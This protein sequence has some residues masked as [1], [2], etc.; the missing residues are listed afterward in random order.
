MTI[1]PSDGTPLGAIMDE[2]GDLRV[3]CG[4]PGLRDMVRASE[5]VLKQPVARQVQL[6]PLSLT[7]L[8]DRLAGRRASWPSLPWVLSFVAA[9]HEHRARQGLGPPPDHAVLTEWADRY[10]AHLAADASRGRGAPGRVGGGAAEDAAADEEPAPGGDRAAHRGPPLVGSAPAAAYAV[11]T[12]GPQALP[13]GAAGAPP[14]AS[15]SGG[16]ADGGEGGDGL[17]ALHAGVLW[18][19]DKIA[20]W[21]EPLTAQRYRTMFGSH[22]VDLL[23]AAEQG[24]H[25]AAG[26]LGLLLLCHDRPSEAGAWLEKAAAGR[27][28][29]AQM[30]LDAPPGQRRELAATIGYKLALPGYSRIAHRYRSGRYGVIGAESYYR[31]AARVGHAPAMYGLALMLL[32]R[33]RV[34]EARMH[35]VEAAVLGHPEARVLFVVVDRSYDPLD[36]D[37]ER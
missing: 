5:R 21:L 12:T 1:E 34:G 35:L 2:L 22:G 36:P 28:L 24:D 30:L 31:A 26:R 7:G 16:D 13:G 3:R 4:R 20:G 29:V 23:G 27:D 11:A 10:T 19:D 14:P 18:E 9:C 32:A 6:Q 8:S 17:G 25:D 37:G 33:G 15:E